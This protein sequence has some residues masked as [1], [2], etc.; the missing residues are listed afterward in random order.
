MCECSMTSFD[1][2]DM[3]NAKRIKSGMTVVGWDFLM[4]RHRNKIRFFKPVRK[5]GTSLIW[6]RATAKKIVQTLYSIPYLPRGY[7]IKMVAA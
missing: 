1:V 5:I 7:K 3:L 2:L 4:I 6:D